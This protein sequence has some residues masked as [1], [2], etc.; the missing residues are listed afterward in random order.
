MTYLIKYFYINYCHP[1]YKMSDNIEK[2][3]GI[4]AAALMN[5][6]LTSETAT[7]EALIEMLLSLDVGELGYYIG[8]IIGFLK[9]IEIIDPAGK[10][11]F[12][13]LVSRCIR[14]D[15]DIFLLL[16]TIDSNIH[17]LSTTKP[18]PLL[19]L[20]DVYCLLLTPKEIERLKEMS[21]ECLYTGVEMSCIMGNTLEDAVKSVVGGETCIC[22]TNSIAF[23]C[24][25]CDSTAYCSKE[26]QKEDW[27]RH[28]QS[29]SFLQKNSQELTNSKMF[30][31]ACKSS[32]NL[33]KCGGC[34]VMH[35]CSKECQ[36]SDW[37][38]HKSF[39]KEIV[40]IQSMR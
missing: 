30:C 29:C 36:R 40:R 16:S 32:D 20:E 17:L 5:Y 33:S 26:C 13:N 11:L 37:K 34:K 10:K 25:G 8:Y 39:C 22:G 19:V 4:T 18:L 28:K 2:M 21:R 27:K 1:H 23:K 14:D 15:R 24:T 6:I 12:I 3:K 38:I 31:S 7:P 9:K 35:Y